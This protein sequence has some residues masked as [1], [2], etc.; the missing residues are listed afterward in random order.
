MGQVGDE[1]P[2]GDEQRRLARHQAQPG[3]AVKV[4]RGLVLLL[5][6][7]VHVGAVGTEQ[8]VGVV[9]AA[10][11]QE[12]VE[13]AVRL[14]VL[15]RPHHRERDGAAGGEPLAVMHDGTLERCTL[16]EGCH[17]GGGST[18]GQ[19]AVVPSCDAVPLCPQQTRGAEHASDQSARPAHHRYA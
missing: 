16:P 8:A 7:G 5:G 15:V 4:D 11:G 13:L 10:Q 19:R 18:G 6:G 14:G 9:A 12:L 2:G 3:A 1:Q 17:T